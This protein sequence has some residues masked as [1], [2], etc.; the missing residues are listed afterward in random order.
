MVIIYH[1]GIDWVFLQ[2]VFLMTDRQEGDRKSPVEAQKFS[3][4]RARRKPT[5]RAR[6]ARLKPREAPPRTPPYPTE[7]FSRQKGKASKRQNIFEWTG[8]SHGLGRNPR[9]LV[10]TPSVP[11]SPVWRIKHFVRRQRP[12]TDK[13]MS[14]G[15]CPDGQPARRRSSEPPDGRTANPNACIHDFAFHNIARMKSKWKKGRENSPSRLQSS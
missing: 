14:R 3:S 10:C 6:R 15:Q 1:A 4:R 7:V 12:P 13:S 9:N 2:G 11:S 8:T 5:R